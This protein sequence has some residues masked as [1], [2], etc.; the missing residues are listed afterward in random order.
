MVTGIV[1][2][3]LLY[4]DESVRRNRKNERKNK[5]KLRDGS[6]DAKQK[7][8]KTKKIHSSNKRMKKDEDRSSAR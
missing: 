6:P 2:I 5:K 3:V 1:D 8:K 7:C 4:S